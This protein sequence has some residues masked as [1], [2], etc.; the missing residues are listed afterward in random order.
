MG[1]EV[2][3]FS[4]YMKSTGSLKSSVWNLADAACFRTSLAVM[5]KWNKWYRKTSGVTIDEADGKLKITHCL[6]HY[7]LI[8]WCITVKSP[9]GEHQNNSPMI[10]K[11]RMFNDF[12]KLKKMAF[13]GTQSLEMNATYITSSQRQ[14][15]PGWSSDTFPVAKNKEVSYNSVCRKKKWRSLCSMTVRNIACL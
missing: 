14:S 9:S 11:M 15:D 1:T 2:C 10:W 13:Y 4:R 3:H 12:F 6:A 8:K 5:L 7:S